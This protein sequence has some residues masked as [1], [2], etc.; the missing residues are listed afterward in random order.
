MKQAD[1]PRF[2]REQGLRYV[3]L[4]AIINAALRN[5]L[6]MDALTVCTSAGDCSGAFFHVLRSP[7]LHPRKS[8]PDSPRAGRLVHKIPRQ[9]HF[10]GGTRNQF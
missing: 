4:R 6:S 8:L 3:P 1:W 7:S 9:R 5:C 2:G 10:E